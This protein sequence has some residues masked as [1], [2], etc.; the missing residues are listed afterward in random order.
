MNQLFILKQ[1]V[2]SDMKEYHVVSLYSE[3]LSKEKR[4]Y[5]YTPKSYHSSMKHYPVLYMHDGQNLFD[6]KTAFMNRSWRIIDSF[7]SHP[8]LPEIIIVGIE[9]DQDRSDELIPYQFEYKTGDKMG[10][11]ADLYLDFI[12]NTLKPFIDERYRTYKSPKNT[13]IMGS[14]F[15]GVNS[16]YAALKYSHVFTRFGC[17]SNAYYYE[18]FF[19]KLKELASKANLEHIKKFYMDVG[20]NETNSLA[21]NNRYIQSNDDMY[22]LIASKIDVDKLKYAKIEN[23]IHHE[24][25]WEIR[26]P[27]IIQFLFND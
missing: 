23:G 21:E 8:E 4:V 13:G 14:S 18:G 24:S 20:T 15:G 12:A 5:I 17:V 1:S 19:G 11:K 3:E 16:T 25:D 2:V 26:F 10:G 7:L 22:Q 6:D 27:N 9:S